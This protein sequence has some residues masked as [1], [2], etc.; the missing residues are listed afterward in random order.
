MNTNKA[1]SLGG[2]VMIDKVEKSFDVFSEV[3]K[4]IEGNVKD[5]IPRI[6]LL[7][8]NKLTHSVSIHQI[9]NTYPAESMEKLGMKKTPV[10]RGLYRTLEK[11]GKN[12]PIVLDKYQ[13]LI[14]KHR[15]VDKKQVID[16]SSSY[17]EGNKAELGM[18]GYSRDRRPDKPQINF[19]IATGIN[20]IPT[21]LTIQKGNTQ[22]KKHMREI[23]KLVPRVIPKNSLLIFDAGANTKPNKE[24]I[25]KME[26]HY[27]TL[28]PKKVKTY[29]RHIK[30]FEG[31]ILAKEGKYFEMNARH[32][33]CVKRREDDEVNYIF[34]CP[35][36]YEDQIKVKEKKFK[37]QKE[38][39]NKMLRKR[40]TEKIPSDKGWVEMVPCLQK[41][42]FMMD[43][44]Y[45]NGTE[46]F[47]IL[48][49][50][51]DEDPMK[52][53]RLYK[54]KDK[55]EKFIRALKEGLELRPIRHWNKWSIIGLFFVCFLANF[56]INLTQL[57]S[58]N[59]LVKNVKLL[60]KYLINL[61]LTIVYPKNRFR[62]TILSN[63]S[64]PILS[65]FGGF[66]WKYRDKSLD[67]RW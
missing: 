54:E 37:R 50:S 25:R 47:F 60:K 52:I 13:H 41:T 36:L 42:L 19:G 44:P 34:F 43:N 35:E 3:F 20:S 46:G 32:Y 57:L 40:K 48:E 24:K 6:K 27:L 30:Y 22:D 51:V 10:E 17:L 29:K 8:Y 66:V 15:L 1:F 21:A 9:L 58:K 4:G 33:Y 45:I 14:K 12:F 64:P 23:L 39:G 65:I 59:P 55:A 49:S 53:L 5:F 2:I 16:F 11:I 38:K 56:L 62:F 28:K 63:V 7:V 26:H 18:H 61:T 31:K 67:L